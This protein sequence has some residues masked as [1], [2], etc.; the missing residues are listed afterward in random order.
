MGTPSRVRDASSRWC[1]PRAWTL[2]AP[3]LEAWQQIFKSWLELAESMVKVQ[4]DAFASMIG[5]T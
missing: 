4:Q 5:A 3:V 1:R 2:F